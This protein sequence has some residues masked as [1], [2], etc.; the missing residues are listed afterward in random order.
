MSQVVAH[1]GTHLTLKVGEQQLCTSQLH[2]CFREYVNF[3]VRKEVQLWRHQGQEFRI[4]RRIL[5]HIDLPLGGWR[6][7]SSLPLSLI[8]ATSGRASRRLVISTQPL[9]PEPVHAE[10]VRDP[11]YKFEFR[12]NLPS[13][14][15]GARMGLLE[16]AP[17]Q[18]GGVPWG[19]P[20]LDA[21]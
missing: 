17:R 4:Q 21:S 7:I 15:T 13:H 5:R 1:E 19:Q 16:A 12:F 10:P 3:F 14:H 9:L 8:E 11:R 2:Y 18:P 6:L 20:E